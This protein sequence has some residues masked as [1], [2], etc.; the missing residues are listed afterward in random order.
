[1][2]ASREDI[3]RVYGPDELRAALNL[4]ADAVLDA[5]AVARVGEA[6]ASA[7]SQIDAYV[8]VRYGLPL[9]AVPDVLRGFAVDL[10]LYRL[11]LANGRPRDE[12]R[13]RYDDA[14]AFLRAL[15]KGEAQLPG[16]DAGGGPADTS[17]AD[18]SSDGVGFISGGRRFGRDTELLS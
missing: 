5:P 18:G 6:L 4:A 17:V 16:I 2:Y 14:V 7:A 3:E 9:P 15:A 10:A 12:L 11:A 13:Q 1:M 8:A